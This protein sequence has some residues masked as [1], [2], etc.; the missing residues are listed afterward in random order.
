M[1]LYRDA[2]ALFAF[3]LNPQSTPDPA[4]T[5]VA[6]AEAAALAVAEADT[7]RLEQELANEAETEADPDGDDLL[8]GVEALQVP[9][10][11]ALSWLSPSRPRLTVPLPS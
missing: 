7:A 6:E 3:L 2:A 11:W 9:P 5:A 1:R 8:A 10:L 4:P